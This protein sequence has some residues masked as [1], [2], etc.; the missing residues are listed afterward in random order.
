MPSLKGVSNLTL[1]GPVYFDGAVTLS[2]DC[3]FIIDEGDDYRIQT[4]AD[5]D[6][7]F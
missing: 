1:G 5:L 7:F 2:G 6:R 3:C 4:Q